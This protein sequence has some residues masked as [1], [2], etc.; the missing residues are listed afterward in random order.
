[1]EDVPFLNL[2][3]KGIIQTG[4]F[5]EIKPDSE[6][7][8]MSNDRLTIG[9]FLP[10]NYHAG[11]NGCV[12]AEHVE[13]FDKW[14]KCFYTAPLPQN[15]KQAHAILA[16]LCYINTPINKDLGRSFG[17]LIRDF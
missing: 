1:M 8:I 11:E 2:I 9:F 6:S 12:R 16:D 3:I 15:K 5:Y 4:G 7:L 13:N 10:G 14:K 17:T